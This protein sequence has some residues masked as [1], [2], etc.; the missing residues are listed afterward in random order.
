MRTYSLVRRKKW[1]I[2]FCFR[3]FVKASTVK[4]KKKKKKKKKFEEAMLLTY[5]PRSSVLLNSIKEG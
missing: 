1:A 5:S 4:K 2:E 3:P